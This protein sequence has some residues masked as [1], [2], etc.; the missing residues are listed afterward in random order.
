MNKT[1]VFSVF[2]TLLLLSSFVS[3]ALA[4]SSTPSLDKG[5]FAFGGYGDVA[6]HADD[7][8]NSAYSGRFVPILLFRLNDKM[9]VEAELEFSVGPDGGTETE[10]EYA[11]LH[12]F[13]TDSITLTAGKFLLPFGQ[14]GPNLHPSWINRLPTAPGIY[15][16]HGGNGLLPGVIPVLSDQ[17]VSIQY[18]YRLSRSTK[19]FV[20]VFTV[21]GVGEEAAVHAD[22]TAGG[23]A[24]EDGEEGHASGFPEIEFGSRS[25]D[26]NG[27]KAIGGRVALA[28][29]PQLEVG[30]SFYRS[31]YDDHGALAFNAQAVDI[32]WI[33]TYASLRGEFIKTEA[34]SIMDDAGD[35][36][37]RKFDRNGWYVQGAWSLRQ[38]GVQGLNP[39]ELVVRHS[40]IQKSSEGRRWTLGVNDWLSPSTV[41]KAAYE[42]TRMADGDEDTRVFIQL[43]YGF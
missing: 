17:G 34:E 24:D 30:A 26:N 23:E 40:R 2:S 43:S 6:Y 1:I 3:N 36:V 10:L 31:K 19:L 9:H 18:T 13:L 20:D 12:Y 15:G 28:F 29:L 39:F 27:N 38:L 33:G 42:R 22:P 7:M 16:G 35:M 37:Q 21:N 4:E 41:L 8:N 25:G 5:R 11:D 32:N 14:F